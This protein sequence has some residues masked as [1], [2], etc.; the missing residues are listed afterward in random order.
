MHCNF[1]ETL[2]KST[3]FKKFQD[4]FIQ[5]CGFYVSP[6]RMEHFYTLLLKHLKKSPADTFAEYYTHLCSPSGKTHFQQFIEAVTIGETSFFRN[7][8]QWDIFKNY[9]IPELIKN[10]KSS[11]STAIKIWS[12]GC[13]TGEEVYT[14]AMLLLENMPKRWNIQILGTDINTTS[15]KTCRDGIYA[16]SRMKKQ[17]E[18]PRIKKYFDPIEKNQFRVKPLLRK[19][20]EFI[21]HNLIK[22]PYDLRP[23]KHIDLIFCRN[24]TLYFNTQTTQKVMQHFFN[25]LPDGG[26]LFIGDSETLWHITK[27]FK[28]IDFP[29]TF[30]YQKDSQWEGDPSEALN[31][32]AVIPPFHLGKRTPGIPNR[33]R[34]RT[35]QTEHAA[36]PSCNTGELDILFHRGLLHFE[37]KDFDAALLCFNQITDLKSQHLSAYFVKATIYSNQAKYQEAMEALNHVLQQ[38]NLFLEAYY[39]K[40]ILHIKLQERE[41]AIRMLQKVLYLDPNHV[42]AYFNLAN[43]YHALKQTA[44]AKLAWINLL[45]LCQQKEKT[46]MVPMSDTWTYE[47]LHA[48][49]DKALGE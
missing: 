30:I 34:E 13:S 45:H 6:S 33:R 14:I 9:V 23:M 15:L 35:A 28:P 47:T 21:P 46:S 42:L 38:D 22:D 39:L 31:V 49:A 3:Y 26:F 44:E 37:Q 25:I 7:K 48:L 24:V 17:L 1:N 5:E 4:L 27:M 41:E 40:S 29:K 20:T 12:A 11:G 43:L 8:P 32:T 2:F 18:E 36:Q 16:G 10:K 19:I